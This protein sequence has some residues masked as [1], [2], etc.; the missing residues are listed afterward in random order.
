M[1]T[2]SKSRRVSSRN[3]TPG[4]TSAKS[5]KKLRKASAKP[6]SRDVIDALLVAQFADA[7]GQMPQRRRRTSGRTLADALYSAIPP[8]DIIDVMP[9]AR[10]ALAIEMRGLDNVLPAPPCVAVHRRHRFQSRLKHAGS[11]CVAAVV[12]AGIIAATAFGIISFAPQQ[13]HATLAYS[14]AAKPPAL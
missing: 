1:P 8:E 3:I 12:S 10:V 11:H 6:R 13:P 7:L 9:G 4:I 5:R 2:A 14:Q